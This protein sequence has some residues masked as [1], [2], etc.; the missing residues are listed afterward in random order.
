LAVDPNELNNLSGRPEVAEVE[1]ELAAEVRR[2]W[3]SEALKK[4]VVQ[5][6][7]RHLFLNAALSMGT[8]TPWDF[9]PIVDASKQYYRGQCPYDEYFERQDLK[10]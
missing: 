3:D 4:E 6:Q 7:R 10:G 5:S 9:R 2:R 1:R 8:Q